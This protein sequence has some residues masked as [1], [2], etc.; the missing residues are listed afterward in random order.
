MSYIDFSRKAFAFIF[1]LAFVVGCKKNDLHLS[2][3]ADIKSFSIE[4]QQS[5]S[6]LVTSKQYIYVQVPQSVGSGQNLVANFTIADGAQATVNNNTQVS[7]TTQNNFSSDVKYIV[8]AANH[9][10]KTWTVTVSNSDHTYYW[11]LG[12]FITTSVASDRN[13]EWYY[14]Q[15]NTGTYSGINCG[16]TS[17][18]MAVKWADQSFSHTPEEARNKYL[19]NG[20]WWSTYDVDSYLTDY[21]IPHAII[22]LGSSAVTTRD[23]LK[24]QLDSGRIAVACIDMNYVRSSA[25]DSYRT[26]KFYKT[27]PQWGHFFVIKGYQQVDDE[28]YF[29]IYDPYSFG[30]GNDDGTLKG[31]NRFYRFDDVFS[32][33]DNWWKYVYIVGQKGQPLDV[34]TLRKAA[35]P[36]KIQHVRAM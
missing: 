28:F 24:E 26:D 19:E 34:N 15:G 4:G 5:N 35:D 1:L 36:A 23:I 25:N 29:Q 3:D 32:A 20:G 9:T 21:S 18:T 31:R 12:H 7:G 2:D 13:Y 14:D 33:T 10:E 17:A 8:T 16:P 27:T 22:P 11:G 30:L 6:N